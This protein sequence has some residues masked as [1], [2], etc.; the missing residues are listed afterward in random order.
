MKEARTNG[1][2]E[3]QFLLFFLFLHSPLRSMQVCCCSYLQREMK[4]ENERKDSN[5][6]HHITSDR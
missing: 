1:P 3:F 5:P 2:E 6:S 4:N